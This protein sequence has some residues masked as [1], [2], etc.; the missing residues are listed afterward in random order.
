MR[1]ALLI[2]MAVSV[3]TGCLL[4]EDAVAGPNPATVGAAPGARAEKFVLSGYVVAADGEPI[5]K[6]EVQLG[7][8]TARTDAQGSFQLLALSGESKISI[9][10]SGYTP[11]SVPVLIS[12]DTNLKFELQLSATTTVSVQVDSPISAALTQIF[13][14][15]ELP[16]AQPGQPGVTVALP[17]Y[18]SETASGG[19]KAPQYFAP[20]VAGDHGEP[21]AQ[22]IRI[23]DFLFPNNLPANAH[24][25]G[26]ADPNLL[27]PNAIGFVESD[28]GAFDV[29]HGNNAV[30]LAVAY[31]LVTRL[32]P[33]VQISADPRNYDFVSGWSPGNSQPGAWQ[34]RFSARHAQ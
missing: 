14:S 17:G 23:G 29:R 31:G 21:I 15:D 33:F 8:A 28:A 24:G 11:L 1:N 7:S 3:L 19:V 20:G 12:A 9:S 26:Y 4:A 5:A 34:W 10:A 16:Q 18:P 32:E 25:N 27:I 22:Y 30:D 6:A 13:E 2:A